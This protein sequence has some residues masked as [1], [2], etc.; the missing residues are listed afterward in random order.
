[1]QRLARLARLALLDQRPLVVTILL[2]DIWPF[3]QWAYPLG[4]GI[5]HSVETMTAVA[6]TVG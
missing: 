3:T 2:Y 5:V 6:L 4:R 1:M